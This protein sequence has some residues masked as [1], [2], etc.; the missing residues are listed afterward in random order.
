[1]MQS[2]DRLMTIL[3][4]VSERG[5]PAGAAEIADATGLSLSTVSRLMLQFAEAGL[6]HRTAHDRRY[7]LGP[8]LY[9]LARAAD[10]GLDPATIGRPVLERLRDV[11]GETASLHVLRGAQRICIVEAPSHQPLRRVV[12][13]GHAEPVGASATGAVLLA[14][15]RAAERREVLEALAPDE[16]RRFQARLDE[17]RANGWALVIDEWV[18]GLCGLSAAVRGTDGTRAAVSVSGPSSRFTRTVAMA[19]LD[20]I[21]AAARTISARLGGARA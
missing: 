12:P 20:D 16:Q 8:R 17:A 14:D 10:A 1:M 21:L 9:A 11:T 15:R 7:T 19:H 18:S 4:Q 13:V 3:E 2:L 5:D 6:L